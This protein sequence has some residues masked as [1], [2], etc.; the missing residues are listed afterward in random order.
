[1]KRTTH[2]CLAALLAGLL[3]LHA[4]PSLAVEGGTG[5]YLLGSRD[6]L[7]GIVPPPGTYL[8]G[9][10]ILQQ[11]SVGFVSL[12]GI[13]F[14]DVGTDVWVLKLNATRSFEAQMLGGRPMLTFTLPVAGPELTFSGALIS[15]ASGAVSDSVTGLG[16]LTVTPA[17]GWSQGA[18]FWQVSASVFLPTGFYQ[19]SSVDLATRSVDAASIGKNRAAIDPV[20]SYTYLDPTIGV[21]FSAAGGMTFSLPNETTDYQTAP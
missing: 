3:A 10:V 16:D 13:P 1:M 2:S 18:H 17:L 8:S 7:S 11:G 4:S 19:S 5:A 12:G 20:I 9:D 21:E 6:I 14:A 15:G